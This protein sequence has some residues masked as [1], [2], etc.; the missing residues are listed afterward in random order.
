MQT[1]HAHPA[2]AADQI[3]ASVA[4]GQSGQQ[5][6]RTPG[7]HEHRAAIV[8]QGSS[9]DLAGAGAALVDEDSDWGTGEGVTPRQYRLGNLPPLPLKHCQC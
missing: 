1:A 9:Q 8:M 2:G 4:Q 5:A 6:C 7:A 3:P